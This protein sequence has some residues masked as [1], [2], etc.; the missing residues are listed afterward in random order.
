M[1][2]EKRPGIGGLTSSFKE[3]LSGIPDGS[4][5]VF[6]GSVAVCTPFAEL[7][8]YAVKDRSFKM[9]Y[10]PMANPEMARAMSWHQGIG[11]TVEGSAADPSAP[12]AIVVLGGLAMP[13]FGCPITDVRAMI[14][15]LSSGG[16]PLMV[17]VCFMHIFQR[18][19]WADELSF[20]FLIDAVMEV[21]MARAARP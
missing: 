6:T 20:D 14:E 1:V 18:S 21:E 10:V 5:V 19:G 2:D 11:F 13:K 17:G 12:S 4:K 9:V 7:L 15:K 8:A 16:R 3:A